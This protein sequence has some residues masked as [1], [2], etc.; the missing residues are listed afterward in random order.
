MLWV[1]HNLEKE[2]FGFA[3]LGDVHHARLIVRSR[4]WELGNLGEV[5]WGHIVDRHRHSLLFTRKSRD[6]SLSCLEKK[7]TPAA[8]E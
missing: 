6:V 4:C 1:M 7:K 5:I 3:I 2:V 8:Q